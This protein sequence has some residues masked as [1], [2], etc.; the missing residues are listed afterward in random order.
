MKRNG[1][2]G[3]N[4]KKC[5]YFRAGLKKKKDNATKEKNQLEIEIHVRGQ[6]QN[7]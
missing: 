1:G 2:P 6:I 3:V 4:P 5:L 7:C